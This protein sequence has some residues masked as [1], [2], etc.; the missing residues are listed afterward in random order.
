MYNPTVVPRTLLCLCLAAIFLSP[1][2]S[3]FGFGFSDKNKAAPAT[4]AAGKETLDTA[5]DEVSKLKED[6]TTASRQAELLGQV[7]ELM[8][9]AI[10]AEPLSTESSTGKSASQLRS[11]EKRR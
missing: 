5:Q 4:A 6:L 1:A 3:A 7:A 10:D 9:Q 8:Q 2:S 11:G